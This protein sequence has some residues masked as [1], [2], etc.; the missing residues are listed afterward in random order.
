MTAT[1][2]ACKA[3]VA[4]PASIRFRKD[5]FDIARCERCGLLF[6][7]VLP[8]VEELEAIYGSSYFSSAAGDT[9]GQGYERQRT[10]AHS[11][12]GRPCG[13]VLGLRPGGVGT[14]GGKREDHA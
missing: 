10:P 1:C 12:F 9:G 11:A 7:T 5:G 3:S 13:L 6:R 8:S 2:V 14:T 4:L